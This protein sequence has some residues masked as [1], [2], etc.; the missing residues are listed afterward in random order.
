MTDQSEVVDAV[1]WKIALVALENF[2][3][4]P[5]LCCPENSKEIQDL[6][7]EVTKSAWW[8]AHAQT[9][10]VEVVCRLFEEGPGM[11]NAYFEPS[12][13]GEGKIS[14]REGECITITALMHEL[15]HAALMTDPH[16]NMDFIRMWLDVTGRFVSETCAEVLRDQLLAEGVSVPAAGRPQE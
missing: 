12:A 3:G 2:C 8:L 4:R 5:A 9:P 13:P 11:G 14:V 7:A 16:H 1:S 15:A 6:I 10:R